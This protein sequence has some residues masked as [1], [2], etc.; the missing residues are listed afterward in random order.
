MHL[1]YILQGQ[2]IMFP[3]IFEPRG[4]GNRAWQPS[5]MLVVVRPRVMRINEINEILNT[6][7]LTRNK[8]S[9]NVFARSLAWPWQVPVF[10]WTHRSQEAQ[11]TSLQPV[12]MGSQSVHEGGSINTKGGDSDPLLEGSMSLFPFPL[13]PAPGRFWLNQVTSI[14][15]GSGRVSHKLVPSR[16]PLAQGLHLSFS[17]PWG[18]SPGHFSQC[19]QP[20]QAKFTHKAP[21]KA[22]KRKF[23]T[24]TPTKE[25]CPL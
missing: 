10:S 7:L 3:G 25:N 16:L 18:R 22:V 20:S 8:L 5:K 19:T 6:K 9:V 24:V 14:H 1:W 2:T 4:R 17:Q 15:Q 11:E 21:V 13:P 12:A 23:P